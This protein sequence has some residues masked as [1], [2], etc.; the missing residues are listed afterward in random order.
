[1]APAR[2]APPRPR[3]TR[4]WGRSAR[5][6]LVCWPAGPPSAGFRP[7]D[8]RLEG[9]RIDDEE[10]VVLAHFRTVSEV[11]RLDVAGY[12]CAHVDLLDRLVHAV[13]QAIVRPAKFAAELKVVGRI[14]EHA[15][16]R[17]RRQHAHELH[18]VPKHDLIE[19]QFTDDFHG[20][21]V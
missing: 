10:H 17:G 18:A 4:T 11:Y 6:P 7:C 12:T 1:V 9:T 14:G 5:S 2:S 15:V 21:S 3:R 19:R 16:H 13:D 20:A 8:L